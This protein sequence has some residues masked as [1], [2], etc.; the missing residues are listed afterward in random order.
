MNFS[1]ATLNFWQNLRSL[2]GGQELKIRLWILFCRD[3]LQIVKYPQFS[4]SVAP[5]EAG[6]CKLGENR[7]VYRNPTHTVPLVCFFSFSGWSG[8]VNPFKERKAVAESWTQFQLEPSWLSAVIGLIGLNINLQPNTFFSFQYP[9]TK[10]PISNTQ[11]SLYLT[12]LRLWENLFI[13]RV[14]TF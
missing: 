6:S 7:T 2:D 10:Y 9:G 3:D 12:L 4:C 11:T 8:V 14:H 1:A 13:N 5:S